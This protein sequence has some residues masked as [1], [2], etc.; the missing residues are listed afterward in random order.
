DGY[1]LGEGEPLEWDEAGADGSEEGTKVEE[2]V[3]E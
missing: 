2:L 3:A 1:W